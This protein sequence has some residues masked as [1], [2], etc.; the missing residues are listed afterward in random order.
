MGIRILVVED[1]PP[2]ADFLVRGLREEG[3]T[4]E[5]AADGETAWHALRL[6]DWD[7][8]LLDLAC[9]GR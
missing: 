4:V 6:G 9:I 2:I 7:V 3:F 1:E 8:V 5:H